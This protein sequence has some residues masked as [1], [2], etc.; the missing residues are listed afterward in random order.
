MLTN[1]HCASQGSI[2]QGAGSTGSHTQMP[3][4]HMFIHM[5]SHAHWAVPVTSFLGDSAQL[6]SH[7]SKSPRASSNRRGE[8]E[9]REPL[10]RQEVPQAS[11][12][13]REW[14][15]APVEL[16]A[17][18]G[19]GEGSDFLAVGGLLGV[20]WSDYRGAGTG[21]ARAGIMRCL[22]KTQASFGAQR[23]PHNPCLEQGL[24]VTTAL[25]E[26]GSTFLSG[27][28]GGWP[29]RA[30]WLQGSSPGQ[31]AQQQ[32]PALPTSGLESPRPPPSS[33]HHTT[34]PQC[35]LWPLPQPHTL[36]KEDR[37]RQSGKTPHF[38]V[39]H[40]NSNPGGQEPL[41]TRGGEGPIPGSE[42][43][44]DPG[45]SFLIWEMR[46]K[47]VLLPRERSEVTAPQTTNDREI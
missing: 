35:L 2:W 37:P 42:V 36:R 31:Q 7:T 39:S 28:V 10:G 32:K 38:R 21:L 19:G 23:S 15:R 1:G 5:H 44:S 25:E 8:S 3:G 12:E 27:H 16:P 47:V 14:L 18:G 34:G 33:G 6:E 17:E 9:E 46:L 22:S 43:M 11:G 41:V 24:W 40:L 4:T 30:Q 20:G 26:A 13:W 29:H 45:L